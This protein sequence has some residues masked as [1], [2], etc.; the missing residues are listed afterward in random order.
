ML[1]YLA[2]TNGHMPPARGVTGIPGAMSGYSA[3]CTSRGFSG[4]VG[5]E[6]SKVVRWKAMI[7]AVTVVV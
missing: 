1:I 3:T 4:D 6:R 2:L 5:S 7:T